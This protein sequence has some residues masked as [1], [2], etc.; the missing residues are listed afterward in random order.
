MLHSRFSEFFLNIP[1][2]NDLRTMYVIARFLSCIGVAVGIIVLL[3]DLQ[4]VKDPD[5][6]VT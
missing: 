4:N 2:Q 3:M 1:L 5:L 6:V